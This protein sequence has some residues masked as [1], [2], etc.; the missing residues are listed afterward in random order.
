M[1]QYNKQLTRKKYCY[2]YDLVNQIT[3]ECCDVLEEL[4]SELGVDYKKSH[5]MLFGKCPVHG[6]D[7]PTAWNIFKDGDT[8]RG[9]WVCYTKGCHKKWKNTLS[10]FVCGVLNRDSNRQI[11]WWEAV[12]WMVEF[13]GYENIE[14]VKVKKKQ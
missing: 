13:L 5:K 1:N 9:N 12:L 7:N 14:D 11:S 6:G 4:L 2:N 8:V 10:G 3:N